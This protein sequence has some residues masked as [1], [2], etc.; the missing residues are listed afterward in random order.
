MDTSKLSISS[1]TAME[2]A[3]TDHFLLTS[4]KGYVHAVSTKAASA[5]RETAHIF[6]IMVFLHSAKDF[7]SV[8]RL[9]GVESASET[10]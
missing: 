1:T 6:R 10:E 8:L 9:Y 2:K 5:M 7:R 3:T 4:T